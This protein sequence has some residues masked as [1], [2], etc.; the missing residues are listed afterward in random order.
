M[1]PQQVTSKNGAKKVKGER[2]S[3]DQAQ[4]LEKLEEKKPEAG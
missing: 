2:Y 4:L 3:Q 1:G